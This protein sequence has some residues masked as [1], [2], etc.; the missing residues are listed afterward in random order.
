MYSKYFAASLAH[1]SM[2]FMIAIIGK[3]EA[4]ILMFPDPTKVLS[5]M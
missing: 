3:H 1:L 2:R 5:T 4:V